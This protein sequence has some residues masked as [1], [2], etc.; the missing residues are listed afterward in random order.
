LVV[1][2]TQH[3]FTLGDVICFGAVFCFGVVF[4]ILLLQPGSLFDCSISL[5]L[6]RDF[7]QA[8]ELFTI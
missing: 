1:L 3:V 5:L 6:A 2:V 7:F 4:G 8:V